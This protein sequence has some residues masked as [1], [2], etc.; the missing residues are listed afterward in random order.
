MKAVTETAQNFIHKMFHAPDAFMKQ[1]VEKSAEMEQAV[2]K[3]AEVLT[4]SSGYKTAAT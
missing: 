4:S 2:E 1:A 3:S